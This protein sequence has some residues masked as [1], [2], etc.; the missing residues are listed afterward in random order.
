MKLK[1]FYWGPRTQAHPE[2]NNLYEV[3]KQVEFWLLMK[4]LKRFVETDMDQFERWEMKT[5]LGPVYV[6]I[7]RQSDGYNYNKIGKDE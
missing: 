2:G 1:K 6:D 7:S 4:L 5:K 3:M